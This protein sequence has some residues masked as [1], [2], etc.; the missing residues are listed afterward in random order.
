MTQCAYWHAA[1]P[2]SQHFDIGFFRPLQSQIF[3]PPSLTYFS[4]PQS[5]IFFRLLV[6]DFSAPQSDLKH[7]F[8]HFPLRQ[9]TKTS[10]IGMTMTLL[11][12]LMTMPSYADLGSFRPLGFGSFRP[13]VSDLSAPQAR[14]FPP[15]SLRSF[16]PLVSDFSAPKSRIF[17]PPQSPIFRPKSRIYTPP[18]LGFFLPPVS[19]NSDICVVNKYAISHTVMDKQGMRQGDIYSQQGYHGMDTYYVYQ[20]ENGPQS[21]QSAKLFLLSSELGLP[22]PLTRIVK[23]SRTRK[24]SDYQ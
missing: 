24:N 3:P 6:S 12:Y 15:P 21:R 18:R 14:I 22:Q 10:A 13:L 1:K 16:L 4:A 17:P 2:F 20:V 19:S 5:H 7:L 11:V 8:R 23:P 9:R